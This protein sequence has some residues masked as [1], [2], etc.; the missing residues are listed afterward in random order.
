MRTPPSES[1]CLPGF[2]VVLG[3][4]DGPLGN[5]GNGALEPGKAGLSI[6]TSGA[7]RMVVRK[8]AVVS[9]LFC[10]A[11]TRDVWV[12]GGAVSNGVA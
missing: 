7:V 8:P 3:A 10:Y 5:P 11:L 12:A 2:P 1:A 6:G 4:G 9:G